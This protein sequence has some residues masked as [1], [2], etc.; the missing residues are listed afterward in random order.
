MVRVGDAPASAGDQRGRVIIPTHHDLIRP[1][2]PIGRE[3][4]R[5]E[6]RDRA[7]ELLPDVAPIVLRP[8]L[9]RHTPAHS[10]QHGCDQVAPRPLAIRSVPGEGFRY[11]HSSLRTHEAENRGGTIEWTSER[12]S[13]ASE[14]D[15]YRERRIG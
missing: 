14:L 3:P 10:R 13:G 12:G 15:R 5:V 1:D 11:Q 8:F 9:A 7:P 2:L 6:F 4:E